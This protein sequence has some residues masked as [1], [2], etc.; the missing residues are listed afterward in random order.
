MANGQNKYRLCFGVMVSV[1]C[2]LCKDAFFSL[3]RRYMGWFFVTAIAV[4]LLSQRCEYLIRFVGC[5]RLHSHIVRYT[6][7]SNS[8]R[9]QWTLDFCTMFVLITYATYDIAGLVLYLRIIIF[10][11]ETALLCRIFT[12][13]R[14]HMG[15]KFFSMNKE[16][17]VD[18]IDRS[19]K[20]LTGSGSDL[21]KL[22]LLLASLLAMHSFLKKSK[23]LKIEYYKETFDFTWVIVS[24]YMFGHQYFDYWFKFKPN[25]KIN[26][27]IYYHC[28]LHGTKIY[29]IWKIKMIDFKKIQHFFFA[30]FF[31]LF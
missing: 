11:V 4:Y 15:S 20:I 22:L 27:S 23:K 28:N 17:L 5:I 30:H 6:V 13:D 2:A 18:I 3:H 24:Q 10:K 29:K 14:F 12:E 31:S 1:L 7:N 26:P 19:P 25:E 21:W 16:F 8:V 9:L